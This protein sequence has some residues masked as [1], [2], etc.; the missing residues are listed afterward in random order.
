MTENT[1]EVHNKVVSGRLVFIDGL[2]G[3][4]V[5]LVVLFHSWIFTGATGASGWNPLYYGYT[6]VHLFL[7]LSGFCVY[8]PFAR[9][10]SMS[11]KQYMERRLY[12]IAP[13]YFIAVALWTICAVI[14]GQFHLPFPENPNAAINIGL[15]RSLILHALFLHNLF[16][17]HILALAGPFWSIG[18]EVQ[19]YILMP[20]LVVS[21]LRFGLWRAVLGAVICTMLVR[22]G[23]ASLVDDSLP[24]EM[25]YVTMYSVFGRWGEFALGMWAAQLT[26]DGR[27]R[28][29]PRYLW[30]AIA[31]GLLIVACTYTVAVGKFA[32]LSDLLFGC[33]YFA[34][35]LAGATSQERGIGKVLA[36]RWLVSLG[37]ISYSVYLIHQ[38]PLRLFVYLAS[39]HVHSPLL[40]FTIA[41]LVIVPIAVLIGYLFFRLVERHFLNSASAGRPKL[42]SGPFASVPSASVVQAVP[43]SVGLLGIEEQ[44]K[45]GPTRIQGS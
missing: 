19:L 25:K 13:P 4:A 2:R 21:G 31:A 41:V 7:V 33:G 15:A 40:L 9:G 45:A 34:L 12:R 39:S 11:L 17:N 36:N 26:A 5:L 32:P 27:L 14:A 6:G 18:L 37:T 24:T 3:I 16:P 1:G 30:T 20:I 43:I 42:E 38:P 23:V 35:I 29:S 10:K 44:P 8:W 22:F 28:G